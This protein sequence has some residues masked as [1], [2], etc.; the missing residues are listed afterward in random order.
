MLYSQELHDL[1]NDYPFGPEK[2]KVMKEMLS[3]Y[4]KSIREK[5]NISI[6]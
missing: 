5:F 6:G 1:H 2:V 3:P 4:C